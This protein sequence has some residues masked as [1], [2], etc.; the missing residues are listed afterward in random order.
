MMGDEA[1]A[2]EE[3]SDGGAYEFMRELERE[4][5]Q[6][7]RSFNSAVKAEVAR[8]LKRAGIKKTEYVPRGNMV[9]R[10]CECGCGKAFQAREADIKRG[11][12]KFSSKACA[13]RFKDETNGGRY[14]NS[15]GT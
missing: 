7:R 3:Q 13:A 9:D 5:K 6:K 15:Y 10:V 14:R 4:E 2:L 8:Q 11:W 1:D 12:G